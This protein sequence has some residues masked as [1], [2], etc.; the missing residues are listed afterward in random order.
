MSGFEGQCSND[1]IRERRSDVENSEDERR[2]Y[3]KIGTFKKKAMNASSK[4][5]HSLKKRGKKK[6]DYRVPSVAIEDVRDAREETAVLELRQRLV[7]RGSL[8]P[9]HDD[10]HSLL[11]FLKARD[12]NIENTIQM[13][14]EMLVW[15]K[16]Y[17]T[18]TI[19]ED[20]EFEELEGVL[21][22]YPQGYHGVDK[23]GRPVYIE[24]LGKAHPSRL[25]RITTIDRYL[26][27]HVQEFEKALHE[28]F[29]ACSIAAKRQ[30]FSTT[31]I[32]DVQGLGI[33][34]FSPTA[35]NLLSSIAKI[36]SCYYPETL[37]QMYIV[38]A[39]TGFKKMLWPAAQKFLDP[40]TTA[41]IQILESKSLYKL[42][43]VIDSSQLPDFLG[44]SCTCSRDGGCLKTNKGPWND[45]NIMKLVR[46][47]EGTFVR[48][49]T[50]ASNEQHN[51]DSFQLQSLK[52]RCSGSSTAE[53][54]SDFNDY[55]SP[56]RQ[57]SGNYPR[58]APVREE[59]RA[60]DANGY[61][62]CDDS[63]LSAQNVIESDQL[64]LTRMQSLQINDTG[65]V[66]YRTNSEGALVSNLLS[67]IKEKIAKVNFL[68]VPQALASFIERLVGFIFSL[69]FE[70]WR[71]PNIVH[72]SNSTD[73]DIN[74]HSEAIEAATERECIL[75]CE[76][77]LQRL[78]KVFDELNKKPDGMPLEK[79]KMLMDSLDRI[80]SVEF[81]LEK[82]KRVLH[83]AVMKQLEITDLLEN[84]KQ[85]KFRQ[86]R[87]LC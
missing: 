74:N 54:G 23:E 27:Y 44:G 4:F 76:Q 2:Q 33:K 69:R 29:P 55:S 63:A 62:S 57:R 31:T 7:E 49:I 50:R 83:A 40:K 80:K 72:P 61:Y 22:Y 13:W 66:A 19:L 12:F 53:S 71:T 79:E 58:L 75:P 47:A 59:V 1:E 65:N 67:V 73:R 81:D 51:F 48:Q 9:K 26:R 32:L 34:N 20:F 84:M 28:K 15:R 10:Y 43:E 6:I 77:R 85:P 39:G 41:K 3:S 8:P 46:N 52:E 56:T 24:R 86:R 35:T 18:D 14:E 16:E 87:L 37:H 60:P 5:T 17:G 21:Q 70:F 25:M 30:I 36:D 68:Y 78:E 11:R 64:H 42:Q 38:N 82:T 45:H